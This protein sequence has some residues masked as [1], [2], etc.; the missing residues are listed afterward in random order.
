MDDVVAVLEDL[1]ECMSG[2]ADAAQVMRNASL[3]RVTKGSYKAGFAA[4]ASLAKQAATAPA[5]VRVGGGS[6]KKGAA[7]AKADANVSQIVLQMLSASGLHRDADL[8][9]RLDVT[10]PV[11]LE[12]LAG[13][14][15]GKKGSGSRLLRDGTRGTVGHVHQ[16]TQWM[17]DVLPPNSLTNGKPNE[18]AVF[19]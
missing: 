4:P 19:R 12:R 16:H 14:T 8:K 15:A 9:R 5:P 10:D 18:R 11:E 2:S 3:K 13:S 17:F 6:A 1:N 7:G